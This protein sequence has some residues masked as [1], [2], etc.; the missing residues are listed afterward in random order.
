MTTVTQ[1]L[2][3]PLPRPIAGGGEGAGMAPVRGAPLV[4]FPQ[5]LTP[6]PRFI[7]IAANYDVLAEP[8]KDF[9]GAQGF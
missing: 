8:L 1:T 4:V 2:L 3:Q 6:P 5:V 7:W 9:Q